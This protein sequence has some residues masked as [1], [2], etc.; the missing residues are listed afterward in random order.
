M[1]EQSVV[2]A[3][4]GECRNSELYPTGATAPCCWLQYKCLTT[5]ENCQ[6]DSLSVSAAFAMKCVSSTKLQEDSATKTDLPVIEE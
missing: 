1:L 3:S 6:W 2:I 4:V 5:D